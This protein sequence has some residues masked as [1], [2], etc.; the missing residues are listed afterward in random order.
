MI[1]LFGNYSFIIISSYLLSISFL[2]V[3]IFQSLFSKW[4]SERKLKER[5][6]SVEKKLR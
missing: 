6:E 5:E 3:L 2:L 1:E 4:K